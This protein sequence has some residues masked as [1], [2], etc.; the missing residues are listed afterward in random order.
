MSAVNTVATNIIKGIAKKFH[1][2]KINKER[3]KP[4]SFIGEKIIKHQDNQYIKRVNIGRFSF[5]YQH[6][7]ELLHTYNDIFINGIYEFKTHNENPVIIDCGANIGLSTIYFRSLFLNAQ[8]YSFEADAH[9]FSILERNIKANGL[10]DIQLYQKAVW[11]NDRGVQFK[12]AGTEASKIENDT[13][14]NCT[15][16]ESI[17]LSDFLGKFDSVQFL[18]LDIEG[19]EYPVLMDCKNQLLKVEHAFIEYHGKITETDKLTDIINII[20]SAG[21]DMYI[22]T[23]A[24]LLQRPFIQKRIYAPYDVQL[25]I[26]CYRNNEQ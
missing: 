2:K 24:D 17:K 22:K 25:N 18:K 8:I 19:A 6:P 15:H 20:R 11:V 4:I 26:F 1:R 3:F 10:S 16:V 12:A 14:G 21:F 9:N 5:Y 23:A 13:I 7:Y